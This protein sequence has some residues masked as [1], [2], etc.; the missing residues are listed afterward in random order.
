MKGFFKFILTIVIIAAVVGCGF[1][2]YHY[3]KDSLNGN[4]LTV[5][6]AK[7]LTYTV[8]YDLGLIDSQAFNTAI[9]KDPIIKPTNFMRDVDN[10]CEVNYLQYDPTEKYS[11]YTDNT[12]YI[13]G[14]DNYLYEGSAFGAVFSTYF[15]YQHKGMFELFA[16]NA[17]QKV[18]Y[19]LE[20]DE[21]G[22]FKIC[23]EIKQ[24]KLIFK[25]C[26]ATTE[27]FFEFELLNKNSEG[28][29]DYNFS[30]RSFYGDINYE[31]NLEN[32]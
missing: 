9:G 16:N 7:E 22:A 24:S 20:D 12:I 25:V 10:V 14:S 18:W 2:G 1:F 15:G 32:I 4:K 5:E 23:Y 8:F 29:T 6:T 30:I 28:I 26:S 17:Q 31:T 11:T 13:V 19:L 3:F 21:W 27:Y